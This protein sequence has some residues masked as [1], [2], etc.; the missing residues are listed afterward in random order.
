MRQYGARICVAPVSFLFG[1]TPDT[2]AGRGALL[3]IP[4][5][6]CKLVDKEKVT[7]PLQLRVDSG[8]DQHGSRQ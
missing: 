1:N 7:N 8:A 3:G 2:P 4:V 6:V 5:F